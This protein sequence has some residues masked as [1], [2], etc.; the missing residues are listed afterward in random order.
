MVSFTSQPLYPWGKRAARTHWTGGWVGLRSG[1]GA[2]T[3]RKNPII[4]P[5]GNRT[6]VVQ[7]VAQSA[8]DYTGTEESL[9]NFSQDDQPRGRES[10]PGPPEY[11]VGE[12]TSTPRC[13]L[14]EKVKLHRGSDPSC[15]SPLSSREV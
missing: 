13:L 12:T 8:F 11:K 2:V 7:P 3:K 5:A 10:N 1:L 15:R 6:S 14:S 9:E 4:A